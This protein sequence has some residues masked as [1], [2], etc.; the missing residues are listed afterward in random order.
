LTN[1]ILKIGFDSFFQRTA[2][3]HTLVPERLTGILKMLTRWA[4]SNIRESIIFTKI[5]MNGNRKGNT[6][7]P[8]IEFSSTVSMIMIHFIW[9]YYFLFSGLISSSFI[10]RI[11]AYS[12]LFGFLYMVYFIRIEGRKDSPYIIVFSIFSSIFMIWIFTVAG[13]SLTK[14]G[15]STR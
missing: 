5:L 4:R 11:F 8:F 12:I 9:F 7:F 13:L 2:V 10:F 14:K 15:W 6:L 1:F 3:S